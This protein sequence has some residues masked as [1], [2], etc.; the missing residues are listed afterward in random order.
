MK[1][2]AIRSLFLA[3]AHFDLELHHMDLATAFWVQELDRD[4]SIEA[5]EVVTGVDRVITIC[6]LVNAL[7]SL[8]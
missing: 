7:H 6:K 8:I 1:F 2:T 4:I 5:S 3:V